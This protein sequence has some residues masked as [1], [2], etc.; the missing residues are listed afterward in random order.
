[1]ALERPVGCSRRQRQAT[2]PQ[3]SLPP[4]SPSTSLKI[5][6][7]GRTRR[8]RSTRRAWFVLLGLTWRPAGTP[9]VP[10]AVEGPLLRATPTQ[11]AHSAARGRTTLPSGRHRAATVRQGPLHLR[12]PPFARSALQAQ[13]LPPARPTARHVPLAQSPM[14]PA[15]RAC[16]V[17][18]ACTS[19]TRALQIAPR[20]LPVRGRRS[21]AQR[22]AAFARQ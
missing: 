11:R 9:G 15:A 6:L 7:P 5:S 21:W 19:H 14:H 22:R 3:P 18:R 12:G 20:A 13:S 10:R 17:L 8:T 16:R 2:P 1:M 4:R